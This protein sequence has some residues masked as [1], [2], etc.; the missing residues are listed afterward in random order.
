MTSVEDIGLPEKGMNGE[1]GKEH[2]H[3]QK[4]GYETDPYRPDIVAPC[5]CSRDLPSSPPILYGGIHMDL[6]AAPCHFTYDFVRMNRYKPG[7]V[8]VYIINFQVSHRHVFV[9]FG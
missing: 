8:E 1:A 4:L 7:I 9:L 5:P 2:G 3:E 6:P